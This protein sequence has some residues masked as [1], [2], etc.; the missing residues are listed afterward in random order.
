MSEIAASFLS[1]KRETTSSS[2]QWCKENTGKVASSGGND[3][4]AH[5]LFIYFQCIALPSVKQFDTVIV[6]FGLQ[7]VRAGRS[8]KNSGS[9]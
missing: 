6:Y 5:E 3:K 9:V 4:W 8:Q 2:L 7:D 1:Q